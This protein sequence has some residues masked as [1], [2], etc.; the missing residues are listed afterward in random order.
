MKRKILSIVVSL[1]LL[2]YLFVSKPIESSADVVS[3]NLR[4]H[5]LVQEKLTSE[6][7]L[8]TIW[9][10]AKDVDVHS[11]SVDELDELFYS[12]PF[13][14]PTIN[15]S[16]DMVFDDSL[17][18]CSLV[19]R[20]E[21][22]ALIRFVVNDNHV[23]YTISELYTDDMNMAISEGQLLAF[24]DYTG[25]TRQL[26]RIEMD[27]PCLE[28][29]R[30][31]S[32][33]RLISSSI[34]CL[35]TNQP[36]LISSVIAGSTYAYLDNYPI[37]SQWSYPICWAATLASI[38]RYVKPSSYGS[39]TAF[40]VCDYMHGKD[41]YPSTGYSDANWTQI[42]TAMNHYLPSPY[43]PTLI[44]SNLSFIEVM[45]V[46]S[47]DDPAQMGCVAYGSGNAH[48]VALTGYMFSGNYMKVRMMNPGKNQVGI[49]EWSDYVS[50]VPFT[51][52]YSGET[53]YWDK[54]VLIK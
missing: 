12:D 42:M 49:I 50:S 3:S 47:G 36:A 40:N 35:M 14:I 9:M 34:E 1:A 43:S 52:S 19:Y 17:W 5:L 27:E 45:T 29:I 26:V 24:R 54:T 48:H 41:G 51:F 10:Y 38:V 8:G 21:V 23:G 25:D 20:D 13:Q 15:D 53:W 18:Y 44:Y 28:S 46:I 39:L 11:I 37:V 31:S 6:D 32:C 7:L 16:D 2:V 30:Y 4:N 22:I 33:N